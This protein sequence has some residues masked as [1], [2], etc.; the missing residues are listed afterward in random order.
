[1][2]PP[3]IASFDAYFGVSLELTIQVAGMRMRTTVNIDDD[4]IDTAQQLT[5]VK[6]RTTLLRI[7][8]EALVER[9][10]ARRLARLGGSEPEA[11]DIP[12]RRA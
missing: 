10:S 7:A 9:E 6:E 3:F 12:R 11:T 2:V 8:L 1:M 5:G 4:L